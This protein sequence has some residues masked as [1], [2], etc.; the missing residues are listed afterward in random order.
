MSQHTRW[1]SRRSKKIEMKLRE[2][3]SICQAKPIHRRN[4]KCELQR[5]ACSSA[6]VCGSIR[7]S[8]RARRAHTDTSSFERGQRDAHERHSHSN[9]PWNA[10]ARV[11]QHMLRSGAA[12]QENRSGAELAINW[13]GR[14]RIV[15]IIRQTWVLH[16]Y[17][18]TCWFCISIDDKYNTW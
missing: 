10:R 4:I 1:R 15:A 11:C 14:Y 6:S 2:H 12:A 13:L 18:W 17:M 9:E 16:W 7:E 8:H 5:T 3:D